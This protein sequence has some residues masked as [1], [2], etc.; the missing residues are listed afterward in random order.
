MIEAKETVT[1][2]KGYQEDTL[3]VRQIESLK[4]KYGKVYSI[5]SEIMEDDENGREVQYIFNKPK[6][7]SY[8][9]YLKTASKGMTKALQAFLLDNIVSEQRQKLIAE[10]EEYPA[11]TLG[12]GQKLLAVLGLSENVNLQKL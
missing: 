2:E 3:T 7:A 12:I 9:R 10:M 4:S 11:F 5:T 6:T 8:D 1:G